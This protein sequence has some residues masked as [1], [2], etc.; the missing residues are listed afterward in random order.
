MLSTNELKDVR[1]IGYNIA[2]I[3]EDKKVSTEKLAACLSCPEIRVQAIL[4]GSIELDDKDLESI[5]QCLGVSVSEILKDPDDG[6]MD[7]NIHYM[8]KASNV[9]DMNK[10]LDEVDFYVRLLNS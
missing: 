7:Y 1:A 2:G 10:I 8:G 4:K 3:M 6:V 9:E 5:A